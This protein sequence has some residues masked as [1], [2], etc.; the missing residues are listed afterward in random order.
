MSY[1]LQQKIRAALITVVIVMG[2]IGGIATWTVMRGLDASSRVTHTHE[3][4][5]TVR[6]IRASVTEAVMDGRGYILTGDSVQMRNHERS[7]AAIFGHLGHF[8]AL[9]AD[10]RTQ[11]ERAQKL[12]SLVSIRLS[13]LRSRI[14]LRTTSGLAATVEAI[15]LGQGLE[16]W[17][18]ISELLDDM[19]KQEHDLLA[20]RTASRQKE[21]KRTI[22][23]IALGVAVAVAVAVMSHLQVSRN[24]EERMAAEEAS[25]AARRA[26]ELANHAKSDFLARMSHELRTP[27]N[28]V[29]G[30]AN[31]LRKNKAGNLREQ[32]LLYIDRIH[33]NGNQ[34]LALINTILDLSKIEA[35][36]AELEISPVAVDRMVLDVLSQF[37]A[38]VADRPV[39]LRTVMPAG[40]IPLEADAGKLRQVL[41]NLIGN[42]VKFT[43][44]GSVTVTVVEDPVTRRVRRI[45]VGDTGPGIS[46]NRQ[47]AIFNAFEQADSGISRRYGG[48]G[49]GLTISRSL[50][51]LMGYRLE[52]QSEPGRGATFSVHIPERPLPGRPT[53]PHQ[54]IAIGERRHTPPL[55]RAAEQAI[56]GKVILVIDDDADSRMLL[57]QHMRDLGCTVLTAS[58]GTEGLQLAAER[59]PD[60]ITLDLLMPDM[61]GWE[62]LRCLRNDPLLSPIPVIVISIVAG[63]DRAGLLNGVDAIGKPC[64][65]DELA[66]A[67]L[68]HLDNGRGRVLFIDDDIDM[69]RLVAESLRQD[70]RIEVRIASDGLDAL[71]VMHDFV[72]DLIVLD[73]IMPRMDG[74]TFLDRLRA[75]PHTRN[76]PVI[77]L[78]SQ[79]L[80]KEDE[81]RIETETLGLLRKGPDMQEGLQEIAAVLRRIIGT[82]GAIAATEGTTTQEVDD[83]AEATRS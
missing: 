66:T 24:L 58:T 29:I 36:R 25:I 21:T 4:I 8:R 42:A 33:A 81:Q 38:Q 46:P 27:L 17:T 5:A 68:R 28:S 9:T 83:E 53:P 76:V 16:T 35:G 73:L 20:V 26:A 13:Q 45:D 49:L 72:P 79:D 67:I 41:L 12:D 60:V 52:L 7:V 11:Q 57:S 69:Q 56:R 61:S 47:E 44:Q 65:R 50:C 23:L 30:F 55:P 78:S 63:E 18:A 32:D 2:G 59:R 10:A 43:A 15:R 19:E 1:T 31:V 75:N 82:G 64:T 74:L 71:E 14:D 22:V 40:L 77:V 48:T 70:Q 34:L 3:V 6:A 37:E 80:T 39:Q 51:Q 62:V 54:R